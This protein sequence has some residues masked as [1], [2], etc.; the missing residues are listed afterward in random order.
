MV[1]QI[2]MKKFIVFIFLYLLSSNLIAEQIHI[3]YT[4][5]LLCGKENT[6]YKKLAYLTVLTDSLK[7]EYQNVVIVGNGNNF[8]GD[9]LLSRIISQTMNRIGYDVVMTGTKEFSNG[10]DE[11]LS[12]LDN[13]DFPVVVSNLR[14]DINHKNLHKIRENLIIE[15]DGVKLGFFGLLSPDFPHLTVTDKRY[16]FRF[17]Y[18]NEAKEQIEKLQKDSVNIKIAITQFDK[19]FNIE[20]AENVEGIDIILCGDPITRNQGIRKIISPDSNITYIVWIDNNKYFGDLL[21]DIEQKKIHK[22]EWQK[23][24]L[25]DD[26]SDEID[27]LDLLKND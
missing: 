26:I 9:S 5:D 4:N 23:I 15:R 8:C 24:P 14:F 17:D 16:Q 21:I 12:A 7:N 3:L 18:Q 1:K 25:L 22:V 6:Q 11:Y 10:L 20:L 27:I 13:I 19:K 2:K